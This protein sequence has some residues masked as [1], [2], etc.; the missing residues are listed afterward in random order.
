MTDQV[1][2]VKN[3]LHELATQ[4]YNIAMGLQNAAPPQ[5]GMGTPAKSIQYLLATSVQIE[6]ASHYVEGLLLEEKSTHRDKR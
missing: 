4:A 1:L 2:L 6:Q 3:A 5:E